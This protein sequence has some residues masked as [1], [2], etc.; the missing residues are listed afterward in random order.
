[1][2]QFLRAQ[3]R[4]LLAAHNEA[5]PSGAA[6]RIP[7][8]Y[9]AA[10]EFHSARGLPREHVTGG[11]MP[12]STL[13]FCSKTLD[14]L[15][16]ATGDKPLIG[17]HVGNFLGVSLTH[18]VNYVRQRNEKS[19]VV[20]IDPDLTH[21]GIEHPQKHVIAILNHFGLQGNAVICVGYST[22][23]SLSNDGTAFL[24]ENG[25]EYD[26]YA[27]FESEQSCEDTLQIFARFRRDGLILRLSTAITRE[28]ICARDRDGAA[29]PEAG[30]NSHSRRRFR[31]LDRDQGGI[32]RPAIE[33]LA[34]RRR[35]RPRWP[36]SERIGVVR[37]WPGSKRNRPPVAR[38]QTPITSAG[39]RPP[40]GRSTH[41]RAA[42]RRSSP[43]S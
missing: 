21:R 20:S 16:P 7:Y 19:V 32:R 27:R 35:R 42:I 13:A 5:Q 4:R 34:R 29:P 9:S 8:S 23:K 14:D 38:A 30:R 43:R 26:P 33:W 6:Q 24:G 41:P 10:I 37:R 17:L 39:I 28:A 36:A 18:F 15:I 3:R 22:S 2:Q 12:E 40:R 31:R 25:F 11:S 1:M